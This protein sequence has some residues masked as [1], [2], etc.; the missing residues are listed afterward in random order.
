MGRQREQQQQHNKSAPLKR[1]R[2]GKERRYFGPGLNLQEGEAALP[3]S[4]RGQGYSGLGV[5][6]GVRGVGKVQGLI[7][8][9]TPTL[10]LL[11]L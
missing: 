3:V 1:P 4:G 9:V 10:S 8:C 6:G 7:E 5:M 11:T 2:L